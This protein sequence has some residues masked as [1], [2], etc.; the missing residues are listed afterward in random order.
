MAGVWTH[1]LIAL[2]CSFIVYKLHYEL[3]FSLA[4]FVGN[5]IP[6]ALKF[7]F[8]AIKQGTFNVVYVVKDSFYH[9]LS[10]VGSNPANWMMLGLFVFGLTALLYHYHVIKKKKMFEYDELYVFLVIGIIVHLIMDVFIIESG[11]W[12]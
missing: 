8:S 10:V 3:E 11:P 5:F 2:L 7:G 9:Q 6:D 4:V 12:I 1:T